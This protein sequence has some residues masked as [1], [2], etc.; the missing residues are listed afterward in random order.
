MRNR[1]LRQT[2]LTH[3]ETEL[4]TAGLQSPQSWP[5]PGQPGGRKGG[6]WRSQ[7]KSRGP[8]GPVSELWLLSPR[9]E[10]PWSQHLGDS[11]ARGRVHL[12]RLPPGPGHVQGS[13]PHHLS[14]A[15]EGFF[16]FSLSSF[17]AYSQW[18]G[19]SVTR[20]ATV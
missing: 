17:S 6:P 18:E 13:L 14:N 11:T 20:C 10:E 8:W 1:G 2:L 15:F 5:G 19:L 12:L 9:R 3:L 16:S 7:G 4:L